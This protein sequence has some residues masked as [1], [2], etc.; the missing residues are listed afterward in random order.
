MNA[1][2]AS[3]LVQA[4]FH[5]LWQGAAIA[6]LLAAAIHLGRP[7]SARVRYAL[8]CLALLAMLA[9]FAVTL[10]WFWPHAGAVVVRTEGVHRVF[11]A[12]PLLLGYDARNLPAAPAPFGW[13]APVW[14]IGV[15]LLSLRSLAAWIAAARLSRAGVAAASEWQARLVQLAGRIRVSRPVT[16]LASHINDVPVVVGFLKPAILV[17]AQLFTGFPPEQLELILVHELAHIRRHDYLVN[18]LQSLAEDLLFYHPAVWWVSSVIRAE[19]ENCCDDVVAAN[20]NA[21]G[22]AEALAALE[23]HRWTAQEVA[24]NALAAN[25][26]N[27]MYRI[28]RLLGRR[29]SPRF[30]SAAF[31]ASLLPVTFVIATTIAHAQSAGTTPPLPAPP[32]P[33]APELVAQAAPAQAQTPA[34]PDAVA[35]SGTEEQKKQDE[36]RLKKELE[37]PYKKWLNQE[38]IYIITN[39]ERKAFGALTTDQERENFIE[40]FW[41]RRDPTPDTVPNEYREE[42]YRRIAYAIENFGTAEIPG[43]K[44][45][46]GMIYIKYGPP[47]E[48]E[49]HS[50]GGTYQ[51]PIEEGGGQTTVFPFE[52]WR[53]RYIEG[54][55]NDVVI[56]FVDPSRKG[57]YHMTSD[58]AEKDAL[59]YVPG[60]GLTLAEQSGLANKSDRFTRT[61]G[62][63]LGTGTMPLPASM[64]QFTRLEQ[65]ANLQKPPQPAVAAQDAIEDIVF[66]GAKRIPADILRNVIRTRVG[67]KYDKL[68]LDRDMQTLRNTQ[69]YQDVYWNFA[70]GRTGWIVTFTVA[71]KP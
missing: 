29:T 27:L 36:A 55:G 11:P 17:P 49:E 54:M 41:L 56:E 25:G 44:T 59:L 46:R 47:D 8:A 15:A 4:L 1:P 70:R 71:E 9:S 42:H 21:R 22:F 10:A 7:S 63:H 65:F 61:D 31:V 28:E 48:R 58:P 39:E 45:D 30:A 37:T 32:S 18:L 23:Q 57:E 67:D 40:Q 20:G 68:A 2:L 16:L 43:W 34:E 51:R 50:N 38:V 14:M 64:D 26:G 13:V 19:R 53:Y 62:T 66:Q 60:A 52:K 6:A 3:A 35:Q 69:A 12:P 33:R 5:F 24:A